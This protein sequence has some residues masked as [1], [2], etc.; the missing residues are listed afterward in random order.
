MA[1]YKVVHH[2]YYENLVE[3][4]SKEEARDKVES[5]NYQEWNRRIEWSSHYHINQKVSGREITDIDHARKI[6]KTRG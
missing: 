6:L 3:A 1:V 2:V 5:F 4:E